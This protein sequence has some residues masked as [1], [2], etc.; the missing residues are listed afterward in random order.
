MNKPTISVILPCY[1]AENDLPN[2][3]SDLKAQTFKDFEMVFVNDGG[4]KSSSPCCS[5]LLRKMQE[6]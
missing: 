5:N 6:L 4:V 2:I 3:F 1:H